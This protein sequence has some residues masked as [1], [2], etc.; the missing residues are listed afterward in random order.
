LLARLADLQRLGRPVC[1]GVSRKGL[2]GKLLGRPTERRLA[3]S[4]AAAC[5][6]LG[7]GAAQVLRVHDVAEARDAVAVY[8]ALEGGAARPDRTAERGE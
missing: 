6:A 8:R 5:F 7:R 1:L 2:L 4:L 3:G